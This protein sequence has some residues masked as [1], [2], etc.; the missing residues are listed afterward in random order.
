MTDVTFKNV[1]QVAQIEASITGLKDNRKDLADSINGAKIQAY[2]LIIADV[3][4][5]KLTAKGKLPQAVSRALKEQLAE[6]GV[7]PACIK[8]Y[9][10]NGSGLLR[11]IDALKGADLATVEAVFETEGLTTEAKIKDRAFPKEADADLKALAKKLAQLSDEDREKVAEF[12]KIEIKAMNE[13]L[14]AEAQA[15]I[16]I[17]TATDVDE[18]LE[19]VA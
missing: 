17:Q 16:E 4:S 13:K 14:S 19:A 1:Q 15:A 18:A 5:H 7:S 2:T 3:S 12:E 10:E 11:K 6:A 8:R 9:V